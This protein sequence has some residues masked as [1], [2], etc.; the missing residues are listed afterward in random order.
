M[1]IIDGDAP[2]SQVYNDSIFNDGEHQEET[3]QKTNK[4]Q[5][6]DS[7]FDNYTSTEN[8]T[9]N[10]NMSNRLTQLHSKNYSSIML[11]DEKDYG[12]DL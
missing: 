3:N 8:Q 12:V 1:Q 4:N 7:N 6:N 9:K 11:S 2:T 10:Y 5:R